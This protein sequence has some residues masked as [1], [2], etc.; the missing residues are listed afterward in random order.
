MRAKAQIIINTEGKVGKVVPPEGRRD[1]VPYLR[2]TDMRVS[3]PKSRKGKG[4]S[5]E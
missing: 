3:I 4:G 5:T 2:V 1:P